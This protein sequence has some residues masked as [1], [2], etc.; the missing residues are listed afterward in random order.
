MPPTTLSHFGGIDEA[1]GDLL[2]I[3]LAQFRQSLR[4]QSSA[5]VTGPRRR[6]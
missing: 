3:V 5:C 1:V 2:Q 6:H 4:V